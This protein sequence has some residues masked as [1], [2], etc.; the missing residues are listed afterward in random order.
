MAFDSVF[1]DSK[2]CSIYSA[3]AEQGSHDLNYALMV[4]VLIETTQCTYDEK[5]FSR[6]SSSLRCLSQC[7]PNRKTLLSRKL[8]SNRLSIFLEWVCASEPFA[9]VS[10]L[11]PIDIRR[12]V[13]FAP[14]TRSIHKADKCEI[15]LFPLWV[16]GLVHHPEFAYLVILFIH[17]TFTSSVFSSY[18]LFL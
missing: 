7:C 4:M 1:L 9:L 14:K 10:I 18:L 16:L 13:L 12:Q 3:K 6:V 11:L 8:W 5:Q 2:C 15:W 17:C